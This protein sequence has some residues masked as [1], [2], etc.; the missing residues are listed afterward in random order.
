[1]NPQQQYQYGGYGGQPNPYQ[2]NPYTQQ[3]PVQQPALQQQQQPQ[4]QQQ[5]QQYVAA[6]TP[7]AGMGMGMMRAPYVDP[8]TQI[9]YAC[10][11]PEVQGWLT[12]QSMWLKDWRR[13]FFLLQGSKLFFCKNEY[14]GPHGMIDLSTCTTVKSADF[15]SR[16]PHSFEI[17]TPDITYLLYADNEKEKDDW[18]GH[19]GRAIV[20]C[21]ATYL[22]ANGRGGGAAGATANAGGSYPGALQ[23]EEEEDDDDSYEYSPNHPYF[24][25]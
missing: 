20:R 3:P 5:S 9:V 19:V 14:E 1:M 17:S 6:P 10:N 4:Y 16:K 7:A 25:D 18:I 8:E 15:K 24:N 22:Q 13:R 12:K 21:S 23:N 11:S 2:P